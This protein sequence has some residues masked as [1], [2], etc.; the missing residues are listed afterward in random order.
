MTDV[1]GCAGFKILMDVFKVSPGSVQ[2]CAQVMREGNLL[3]IAPGGVLEAQFGDE[4]YR[5]LWKK[6]LGFAKAAI[7][8]RAP[9][10]PV[11]TQNIR[12]AFRSISFGRGELLPDPFL[13]SVPSSSSG[14]G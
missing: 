1:V 9:V 14:I 5:L 10:I 8:A 13:N 7:E 3:A 11:F 12:E 2:S 4:R 6:R